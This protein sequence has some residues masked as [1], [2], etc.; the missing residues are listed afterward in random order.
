MAINHIQHTERVVGAGHA[1]HGDVVNRPM[2]E[3]LV[4]SGY[5]IDGSDFAGFAK[6]VH[7]HTAADLVSGILPSARLSGAYSGITR[8]GTLDETLI[9]NP[10]S[11]PPIQTDST[12]LCSGLNADLLDGQEAS[13]FAPAS[14]NH[15][16]L[17]TRTADLAV[18]YAPIAHT[19]VIADITDNIPVAKI[20]ATG[21]PDATT[22]LYGNGVWATP[23]GASGGE[24]NTGSNIGTAG[25][26]VFKTKTGVDLQFKK[27]NAGSAKVTVTDDVANNEVD[28]DVVVGTTANTVAAGDDSRFLTTTQK[29]GLTGGGDAS[30]HHNHIGLYSALGHTHS[31]AQVTAGT[32]PSGDYTFPANVTINGNVTVLGAVKEPIHNAGSSGSSKTISFTDGAKQ[33]LSV[34][35]NTTLT[36]SN[37]TSGDIL[38]LIM[39][40]TATQTVTFPANV[41]WSGGVAPTFSA[42]GKIDVLAF[43][44]DDVDNI[45][46]AMPVVQDI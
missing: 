13:E 27:I 33:K 21:T 7:S 45:Y 6:P 37:A 5:L 42:A 32:F 22:V 26:G 17:Y 18:T 31:A 4:Q 23:P 46:I 44:F 30:S 9:I 16:S 19:H 41:R 28:V 10:T 34:N 12:D 15:D 20:S 11:G 38:Y 2:K 14:H 24:A 40:R 43:M 36:F 29:N 1:T 39:K 25:V 3:L 8:V 35:S